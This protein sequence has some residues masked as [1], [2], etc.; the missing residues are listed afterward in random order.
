MLSST[1]QHIEGEDSANSSLYIT[2]TQGL[3]MLAR[4]YDALGFSMFFLSIVTSSLFRSTCD[5]DHNTLLHLTARNSC[6]IHLLSCFSACASRS[7]NRNVSE[8]FS[9][10]LQELPRLLGLLGTGS[11]RTN[12]CIDVRW[13]AMGLRGITLVHV[14]HIQQADYAMLNKK[15]RGPQGALTHKPCARHS[16]LGL[17]L[18]LPP[19]TR[20]TTL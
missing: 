9:Q 13:V 17:K 11:N 3:Y 16:S 7:S 2:K 10:R 19:N 1:K 5:V 12:S 6:H 18:N 8:E 15:H 4:S 14:N 20:Q